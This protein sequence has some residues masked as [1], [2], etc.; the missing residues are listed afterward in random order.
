M[1]CTP[2]DHSDLKPDHNYWAGV[3]YRG[4]PR[5]YCPRCHLPSWGRWFRNLEWASKDRAYWREVFRQ[6]RMVDRGEAPTAFWFEYERDYSAGISWP[7]VEEVAEGI[8]G[9]E[10]QERLRN[11]RLSVP[12]WK[13]GMVKYLRD[14]RYSERRMANT[15]E[16]TLEKRYPDAADFL[17]ME[18][19]DRAEGC[20]CVDNFRFA[21]LDDRAQMRRYR[22][23]KAGGCCRSC[24][25]EVEYKGRKYVLGF[26]HGH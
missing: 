7:E 2:W 26:N 14:R 4:E 21:A 1:T 5:D 6:A 24:D 19:Q 8:A 25:W 11:L 3:C 20:Y 23:D 15:P 13:G 12:R 9:R 16:R 17:R 10:E 18:F 22:E